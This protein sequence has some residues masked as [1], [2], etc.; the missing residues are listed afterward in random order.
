MV[1]L[2]RLLTSAKALTMAPVLPVGEPMLPP[3]LMNW[4]S[5]KVEP[6]VVTSLME[7]TVEE[8]SELHAPSAAIRTRAPLLVPAVRPGLPPVAVM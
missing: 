4:A 1:M 5:A 8:L 2:T 7:M 6:T 3:L